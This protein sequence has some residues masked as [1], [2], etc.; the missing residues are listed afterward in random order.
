MPLFTLQILKVWQNQLLLQYFY[1]VVN[2]SQSVCT[3]FVCVYQNN[4]TFYLKSQINFPNTKFQFVDP[5][6]LYFCDPLT[7][8]TLPYKKLYKETCMRMWFKSWFVWLLILCA[9]L[10]RPQYPDIW[11]YTILHSVSSNS[12]YR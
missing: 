9:N 8:M 3:Y 5:L 12:V 4:H 1:I 6:H 10:A 2:I 7:F 11:W